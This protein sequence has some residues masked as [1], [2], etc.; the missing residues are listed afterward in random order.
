MDAEDR[1]PDRLPDVGFRPVEPSEATATLAD[2]RQRGG[3]RTSERVPYP[4]AWVPLPAVLG[5]LGI[6]M[7]PG[8]SDRTADAA[9]A[10]DLH[11]DLRRLRHV[12][13]AQTLVTLLTD[14]EIRTLGIDELADAVAAHG[15]EHLRLAVEDG[16]AP[17]AEQED[18]AMKLLH[19][20]VQR[21]Q[22]GRTV[23]V[24]CR[25]GQGRSGTV[26]AMVAA[27]LG[28]PPS[29]AIARVRAV[30]PRAVETMAQEAYVAEAAVAWARRRLADR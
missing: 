4:V 16:T 19:A 13:K 2:E 15:I 12:H 14:D 10:R 23:V 8:R 6:G 1:L 18:A 28:E 7:A 25:A 5:K 9:W 24:H 26:A 22:D 30:V 3:E 21:L 20:I 11:A 29:A 17:T 27:A